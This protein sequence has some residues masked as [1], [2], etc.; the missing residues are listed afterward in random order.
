MKVKNYLPFAMREVLAVGAENFPAG[1]PPTTSSVQVSAFDVGFGDRAILQD[2]CVYAYMATGEPST[3]LLMRI[4]W[5]GKGYLTES[6]LP[7]GLFVNKSRPAVP[8]WE[9]VEPYII[10]PNQNLRAR[11]STAINTFGAQGLVFNGVRL[12][13]NRPVCLYDT[14]EAV[15]GAGAG[16]G[17]VDRSLRCPS[18][19]AVALHSVT[20]ADWD[21]DKTANT[22]VWQIWSPGGREWFQVMPSA[23]PPPPIDQKWID[24]PVDLFSLEEFRG[25]SIGTGQTLLVE[26]ENLSTTAM[27]VMV[28]LRG[29]VEIEEEEHHG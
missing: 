27:T 18:D 1:V 17:F 25:W 10:W 7:A 3:D 28:T 11:M 26:F 23:G 21:F 6:K 2:L 22:S 20:I 14:T 12:K 9:F 5:D 29:S 8:V 16:A 4:G 15:V 19:S 13:D 24:P